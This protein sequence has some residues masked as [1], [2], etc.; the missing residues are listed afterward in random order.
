M[1]TGAK[2]FIQGFATRGQGRCARD[3]QRWNREPDD[4]GRRAK[5]IEADRYAMGAELRDRIGRS[6]HVV[7]FSCFGQF[8]QQAMGH[9]LAFWQDVFSISAPTQ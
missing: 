7:D 6:G 9:A 2:R 5:I 1:E 3:R 8:D 4:F